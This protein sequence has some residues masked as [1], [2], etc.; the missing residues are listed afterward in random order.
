MFLMPGSRAKPGKLRSSVQWLETLNLAGTPGVRNTKS[1]AGYSHIQFIIT[2]FVPVTNAIACYI[3]LITSTGLQVANYTGQLSYSASGAAGGLST[4]TTAMQLCGNVTNS[5]NQGTSISGMLIGISTL[6]TTKQCVF[7]FS[8]PT[9]AV[10]GCGA[11][12]WNIGSQ[13]IIGGL[14]SPGVG[15]VLQGTIDLYGI[16]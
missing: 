4:A 2:N 6:P 12:T 16:I 11:S 3:Q 1:W 15:N 8:Q 14:F 9:G 7:N 5:I 13:A 10:G